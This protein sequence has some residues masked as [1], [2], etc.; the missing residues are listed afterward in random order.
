MKNVELTF[1]KNRHIKIFSQ[2]SGFIPSNSRDKQHATGK[3]AAPIG[4]C[5]L[6]KCRIL[7][8]LYSTISLWTLMWGSPSRSVTSVV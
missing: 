7:K 5:F 2:K 6:K 8:F 4:S 1:A 3:K